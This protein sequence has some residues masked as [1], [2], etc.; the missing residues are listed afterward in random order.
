MSR[1]V[2]FLMLLYVGAGVYG[3]LWVTDDFDEL[4]FTAMTFLGVPALALHVL[5]RIVWGAWQRRWKKSHAALLVTVAAAFALGHVAYLNA[6]S[7]AP[8]VV[9]RTVSTGQRLVHKDVRRGGLGL[10]HRQRW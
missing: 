6:I 7:A 10:L 1:Y 3:A 5:L 4:R 8:Q 9:K 2:D